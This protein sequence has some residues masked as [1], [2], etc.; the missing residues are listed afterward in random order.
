M[1]VAPLGP[2]RSASTPAP[3]SRPEVDALVG[4][5]SSGTAAVVFPRDPTSAVKAVARGAC[6]SASSANRAAASPACSPYRIR[7]TLPHLHYSPQVPAMALFRE[8][9]PRASPRGGVA[10]AGEAGEAGAAI[11]PTAD[12]PSWNGAK[13]Q[14]PTPGAMPSAAPN[15]SQAPQAPAPDGA[16][17]AAIPRTARQTPLASP[18]HAGCGR[19][20]VPSAPGLASVS[21]PGATA[22]APAPALPTLPLPAVLAPAV[23]APAVPTAAV[24]VATPM[25]TTTTTRPSTAAVVHG[26]G[27]VRHLSN[28]GLVEA[29]CGGGCHPSLHGAVRSTVPGAAH[30]ARAACGGS[31]QFPVAEHAPAAPVPCY[32]FPGQIPQASGHVQ[33]P[34]QASGT[35]GPCAAVT[36]GASCG[37]CGAY[38]TAGIPNI[39]I[40]T[41]SAES[42]PAG[43]ADATV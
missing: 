26:V 38:S 2:Q 37:G 7:S 3:A 10:T 33:M 4:Q 21:A 43:S 17:L 42:E 35:F 34:R 9:S 32:R 14:D 39:G 25:P 18:M 19:Q 20:D 5:V 28:H 40:P 8:A 24:A 27:V 31:I 29:P 12:A 23:P 36:F 13:P 1:P 22:H 30:A 16:P 41:G 6:A 11:G 15:A